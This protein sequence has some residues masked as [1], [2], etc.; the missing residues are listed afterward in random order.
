MYPVNLIN[1]HIQPDLTI[2]PVCSPLDFHC[3]LHSFH[4][5]LVAICRGVYVVSLGLSC[6]EHNQ[7]RHASLRQVCQLLQSAHLLRHELQVPPGRVRA[8]AVHARAQ[9]GG[10]SA[11]LQKHQAQAGHSAP[12]CVTSR[13]EAGSGEIR[14]GGVEAVQS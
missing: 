6:A 2:V 14:R 9:G 13:P 11:A 8:A 10:A 5:G 4:H 12:T 1:H 7:H 3:D